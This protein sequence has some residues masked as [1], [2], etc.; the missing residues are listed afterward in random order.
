MPKKKKRPRKTRPDPA[1]GSASAAS[2]VAASGKYRPER[3]KINEKLI[4]NVVFAG[5]PDHL[6]TM[7]PALI[8]LDHAAHNKLP[9]NF[10]LDAARILQRVYRELGVRSGIVPVQLAVRDSQGAGTMYGSPTPHYDGTSFVG[11]C[12]LMLPDDGRLIDATVGQFPDVA[13]R[14]TAPVIAV[15]TSQMG[16]NIAVP[17]KDLTL[18]YQPVDTAH[19][20][21]CE[22]G[23]S[24]PEI[25][26]HYQHAAA[27]ILAELLSMMTLTPEVEIRA[28][29]ARPPRIGDLLNVLKDGRWEPREGARDL[30]RFPDGQ[31]QR[32]G[33]LLSTDPHLTPNELV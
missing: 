24:S 32:L 20:R 16:I 28:R 15:G 11:H 10:C 17:R 22:D 27:V 9:G 6:Y 33:D 25:D 1:G 13:E 8:L 30:F 29:R 2:R 26:A 3:V 14:D 23:P 19:H 18:M 12:V 5:E 31:E 21:V 7:L 4:A